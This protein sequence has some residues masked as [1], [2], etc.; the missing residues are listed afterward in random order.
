VA[1]SIS[2][3]PKPLSEQA[4]DSRVKRLRQEGFEG[5]PEFLPQKL[6]K[7]IEEA[8]QLC[9]RLVFIE[10]RHVVNDLVPPF[11]KRPDQLGRGWIDRDSE[12]TK[13]LREKRKSD[14]LFLGKVLRV[15]VLV[16]YGGVNTR[17]AFLEHELGRRN[18]ME[19]REI[20]LLV[21]MVREGLDEEL[22]RRLQ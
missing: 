15:D 2:D 16:D 20:V 18:C 7:E 4:F 22:I 21:A 1:L 9:A 12:V 6:S 13:A 10:R 14:R 8:W 3:Y 11:R 19:N 17:K 5:S